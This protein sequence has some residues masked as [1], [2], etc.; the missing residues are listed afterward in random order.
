MDVKKAPIQRL[1]GE[2]L[3]TADAHYDLDAI[4]F[5]TGFDAMTGTL[6]AIDIRVRDGCRLKDAWADGPA[7]YLGLMVAG[8]P[9]LFMINGPGS[10]SVKANM[11]VALEQHTDWLMG[12]LDHL[13]DTGLNRVEADEQAQRD[14][15]EHAP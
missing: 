10:P 5:A 8:L 6:L 7:T 13:R 9:N 2:G 11:I 12:L 3:E 14:W 4:I 15:V 1:T